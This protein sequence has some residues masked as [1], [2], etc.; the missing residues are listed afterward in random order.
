M[1]TKIKFAPGIDKQDTAVGAEGRWVDSDNVRFRYGLP[2]KVGGWQS[3]LT[4]TLV[5]VARKQHAFVDQDGNRYVAIGTDKFLIVYFEGQ[6]FDVTPLATTI[7]AATFTFNGSTTITIT[8]SAAHN[9]EDGDIVLFDSVTLPG[10]TGLSASDFEDKLFQVVTT[11]TANTFTITF[12]SSGSAAS[13][14]SVDIKPYERVGPAAQT[15]GYGFGISQYGGTVQGAQTTALNGALLADTAGTGGS[16]TAVTVVS[17]TNF[18]SA[19]TIAIANE[20]ITYT[21]KNSTQF[22]GITRGA[23]GTATTGT[24]NGQAHSTAATVTNATEF[25]GWGDA[26]DAATVTL[27]PG[28]WSLSNFGDVLVATIAN[29]KTFTWDSSIAARLTTRASTTTSGFQTTNN[30]TATRVTLIS[31]TTRHLIHLGTETTIGTPS[32]QDDMFIRFSED[33]NINNYTPEATNTAGTQRIQDGTKIVGALVAKENILVWTDNALYTMKF[34]GA[35]FTFGF[36]QV[37]TNCG[38]IGKNAAIEIDGV[39]YWMGNNGFFSFDGTVN[40]LPCSV[41]DYIYD[42]VDTTKGQ[43]VCAGINNLFT[44][45]TWWYPTAG[46]DFNNRYVVY[47]Y[48]QNNAQLPMGNWYTGTNTNSIRTTWIDSLVYPKPYATAYSSSATGSFPAIIGE[49]GLGR[50]VLFEHESGTDQVNPDG[51]TTTLTSFIES[52]SFSLQKDQSEVFLAMRRFLPNFKTLLGNNQVTIAV[53][54]FPADNS[55]ASTLSPFTITSS[56]TKVDTRA[57][58]RYA[59]IKIENTGA[60]ESWRFGTFQVDLQPDGRRG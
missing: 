37:G 6:F 20:L 28:L 15:Y 12:T 33:E 46:S 42:D 58:G 18:P 50:S 41:E 54:D 36:E 31:P 2:E 22:L 9:L 16:G 4:D 13:G 8:T 49:T 40:T 23:K 34:V 27:E 53:K 17:T 5:G 3:L 47:N 26:V 14:G 35:P 19:G 21:S 38:L 44:E 45:V 30:P 29:G 24:S 52:F 25:S 59:S 1:L 55:S 43:Q 7:S 56:T 11:P 10:G 51:S 57:R 60:G 32:T 39:A 48:G